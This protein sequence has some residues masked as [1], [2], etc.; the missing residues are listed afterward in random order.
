MDNKIE[1]ILRIFEVPGKHIAESYINEISEQMDRLEL[2]YDFQIITETEEFDNIMNGGSDS[3]YPYK[4][5][6][7]VFDSVSSNFKSSKSPGLIEPSTASESITTSPDESITTSPDESITTFPDESITTSPD[8]SITTSPDESITTS[9]DESITT[10]PDTPIT[11]ENGSITKL[12]S[13]AVDEPNANYSI[14]NT[15]STSLFGKSQDVKSPQINT[16]NRISIPTDAKGVIIIHLAIEKRISMKEQ[17]F[18]IGGIKELS[19][20][21]SRQ[22]Y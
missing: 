3:T 19:K 5:F 16:N 10:S 13:T 14:F 15:I 22:W 18:G 20:I 7:K 11:A 4:Q 1:F 9:P 21:L 6:E 8:E 12:E 2:K 17:K